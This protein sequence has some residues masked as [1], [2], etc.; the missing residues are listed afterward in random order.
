MVSRRVPTL[1]KSITLVVALLALGATGRAPADSLHADDCLAAPNSPAPEGSWWY[2]RLDW[3]TQRKCW[4][5][6]APDRSLRRGTATTAAPLRSTRFRFRPQHPTDGLPIS[7][8]PSD[9]AS[10]SSRVNLL[11]VKTP[12]SEAITGKIGKLVQQSAQQG[13]A[14]PPTEAPASQAT[15]LSQSGNEAGERLAAPTTGPDPVPEGAA[16]QAQP[17]TAI[18]TNTAAASAPDV[19]ERG[20]GGSELGH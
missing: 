2:Y 6:R 15:P 10:P 4:Y 19:S 1:I 8:D 16:G 5:L 11:P 18:A 20:G 13:S 3:P 9:T 12:T 7:L 14:P 17:A